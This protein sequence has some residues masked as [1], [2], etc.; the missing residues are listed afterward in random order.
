M[1]KP[2]KEPLIDQLKSISIIAYYTCMNMLF[3]LEGVA[4]VSHITDA[5][6]EVQMRVWMVKLQC[7]IELVDCLLCI[8]NY[9]AFDKGV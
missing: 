5:C 8:I 2:V 9:I 4:I 1:V 3:G 7:R 6:Y